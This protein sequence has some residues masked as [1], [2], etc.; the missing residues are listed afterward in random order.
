MAN[1]YEFANISEVPRM[2][3]TMGISTIMR[4]RQIILMAWG[5]AKAQ[6]VKK[7]WKMKILRSFRPPSCKTTIM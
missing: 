5:P 4:S 2:A 7:Q 3:I 6:A 1:A